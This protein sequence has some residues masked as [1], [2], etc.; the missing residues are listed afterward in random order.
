MGSQLT[1]IQI[2]VLPLTSLESL[3]RPMTSERLYYLLQNMETIP[4]YADLLVP[5]SYKTA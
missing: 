5:I 3:V 4:V 2:L 1:H